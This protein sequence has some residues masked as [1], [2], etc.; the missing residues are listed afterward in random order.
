MVPLCAVCSQVVDKYRRKEKD[1]SVIEGEPLA[2]DSGKSETD[3]KE[4]RIQGAK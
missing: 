1:D 4:K 2:T 3:K